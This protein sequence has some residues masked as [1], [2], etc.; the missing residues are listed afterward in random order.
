[1][2]IGGFVIELG[3][4]YMALWGINRIFDKLSNRRRSLWDLTKKAPR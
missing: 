1:M 3:F 2:G 4:I